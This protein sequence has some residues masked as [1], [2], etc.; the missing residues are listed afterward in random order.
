MPDKAANDTLQQLA[1][2][3]AGPARSLAKVTLHLRAGKSVSLEADRS[4]MRRYLSPTDADIEAK[5]RM[6]AQPKL[7]EAKTRRVIEP[8]FGLERLESVDSLIQARARHGA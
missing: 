5:F 6:I 2:A 1:H 3:A 8:V 4:E 7:G